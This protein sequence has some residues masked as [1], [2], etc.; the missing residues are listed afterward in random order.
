MTGRSLAAERTAW[1]VLSNL[2]T[3]DLL[4]VV[5]ERTG[6]PVL[7]EGI[8]GPL[9]EVLPAMTGVEPSP[10]PIPGQGR[11]TAAAILQAALRE[12]G[13]DGLDLE[14]RIRL[15]FRLAGPLQA[16]GAEMHAF[17]PGGRL[18]VVIPAPN[19]EETRGAFRKRIGALAQQAAEADISFPRGGGRSI[20]RDVYW[21]YLNR[22]K[23]ESVYAITKVAYAGKF[24]RHGDEAN[25][26]DWHRQV[27][28]SIERAARLLGLEP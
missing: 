5:T 21:F 6:N 7:E 22:I 3:A 19:P 24:N 16:I 26:Q 18:E 17:L 11:D 4:T 15:G 27:A 1:L 23:G 13:T 8:S 20:A 28:K 10:P 25:S 14:H 12:A 9:E 2:L